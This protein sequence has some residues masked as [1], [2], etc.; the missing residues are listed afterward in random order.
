MFS[1]V[2]IIIGIFL[3]R[4]ALLRPCDVSPMTQIINDQKIIVEQPEQIDRLLCMS[5]D[6]LALIYVL[7]GTAMIFP[8]VSG[9]YK[10]LLETSNRNHKKRNKK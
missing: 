3:I 2:F 4:S 9:F 8:G 5:T 10:S 7:L 1:L 6:Y